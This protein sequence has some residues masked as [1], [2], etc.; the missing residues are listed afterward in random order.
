MYFEIENS[1]VIKSIRQRDFLD[2][3]LRLYARGQT[4]PRF[5]QS[6]PGRIPLGDV[7]EFG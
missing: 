7:P 5:D 3:W 4:M 1:S 2:T 6:V